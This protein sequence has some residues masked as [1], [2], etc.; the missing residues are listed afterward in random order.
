MTSYRVPLDKQLHFLW[1]F[2]ICTGVSIVHP[3]V[4]ITA[5]IAAGL[6]KEW[7][8]GRQQGNAWSWGD[9]AFDAAGTVL[10]AVAVWI[11]QS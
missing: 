2:A 8:D 9:I 6:L 7:H 10:A 1:C 4:G 3:I 11:L 5:A